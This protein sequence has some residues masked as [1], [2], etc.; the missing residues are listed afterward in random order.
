MTL[1]SF[2]KTT[3][4]DEFSLVTIN[5]QTSIPVSSVKNHMRFAN[6]SYEVHHLGSIFTQTYQSGDLITA[7]DQTVHSC[8]SWLGGLIQAL[9]WR[10]R[11]YVFLRT[12]KHNL[13]CLFKSLLLSSNM[14]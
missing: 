8:N 1:V 2:I 5:L 13:T 7:S 11:K 3:E 12:G 14:Q 6:E 4:L 10:S 9:H